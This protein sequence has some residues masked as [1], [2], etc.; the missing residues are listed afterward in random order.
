MRYLENPR[1]EPEQLLPGAK[2]VIVCA[3]SY[4]A[5]RVAS[6][7][8]GV[9]AYTHGEDY[10]RVLKARLGELAQRCCDLLGEPLRAR[11]C[12]DSAPLLERAWAERAGVG[13]IGKST[14]AI[15]P[16]V[17]TA[18][19]LGEI[20]IDAAL[21]ASEP[22]DRGC[23]A[24][25]MCLDACPTQAFVGPYVLDARRCISYLTIEHRGSIEPDLR[26]QM[27]GHLFGCDVCQRVCPYNASRKLP[28]ADAALRGRPQVSEMTALNLLEM[29]SGDYRRLV[30]GSALS[31]A[32]RSQ[33]QRNAAIALG[34]AADSAAVPALLRALESN[35]YELVRGH[36]A[37]ALGRLGGADARAGLI[38]ARQTEHDPAVQD[39]ITRALESNPEPG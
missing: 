13:F 7:E 33:L 35:R 21:P 12:V 3:L 6:A 14:M 25:T 11:I 30:K 24:C 20:L 38:R 29:T 10:H 16:G 17:G 2:T 27:G 15:T 28:A 1:L 32:S 9:A 31:R 23:G 34:N 8:P 39:E 22:V 5:A 19:L 4:G 36:A 37:W 18:T 26:S